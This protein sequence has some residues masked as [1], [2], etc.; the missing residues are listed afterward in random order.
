MDFRD[1]L[2]E[3]DI[4]W[5]GKMYSCEDQIVL[6]IF[7]NKSSHAKTDPFDAIVLTSTGI[8]YRA[9]A[10]RR[11]VKFRPWEDIKELLAEGKPHS[12]LGWITLSNK[13]TLFVGRNADEMFNFLCKLSAEMTESDTSD[14]VKALEK[15]FASEGIGLEDNEHL[16]KRHEKAFEDRQVLTN[17][18]DFFKA[19]WLL[20]IIGFYMFAFIIA[21]IVK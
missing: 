17:G 20:L 19:N 5:I 2:D 7:M 12:I 21:V 18:W 6:G 15:V 16:A 14:E 11:P 10:S 3:S 8:I 4:A 13:E 1:V 9:D